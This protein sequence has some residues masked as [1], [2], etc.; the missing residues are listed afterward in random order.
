MEQKQISLF[1]IGQDIKVFFKNGLVAAGKILNFSNQELILLSAKES[2]LY[3]NRAT[4]S[5]EDSILMI[6]ISAKSA[7]ES[8]L[9]SFSDPSQDQD[10]EPIK[11]ESN[12]LSKNLSPL[13][14]R[15]L[16][17]IEEASKKAKE[18]ELKIKQKLQDKNFEPIE[19][20]YSFPIQAIKLYDE[21]TNSSQPSFEVDSRKETSGDASRN[22]T[23]LRQ[24]LRRQKR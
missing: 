19:T 13:Q 21:P 6:E 9:S 11:T 14:E 22:T 18:E 8:F 10:L 4:D 1:K 15:F 12:F 17:P 24:V 5:K 20:S 7:Q 3:I 16:Q 2:I 23:K